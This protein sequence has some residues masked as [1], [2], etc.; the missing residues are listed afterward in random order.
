MSQPR[1]FVVM[2]F[3]RKCVRPATPT[4]SELQVDFEAVHASLIAPALSTAGCQAFRA[5]EE[6]AAGDI[7]T[8][9]FFELVTADLVLADI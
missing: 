9:M 6:P 8:D 7:R 5:D 3:R 1:A 2:P 4:Q